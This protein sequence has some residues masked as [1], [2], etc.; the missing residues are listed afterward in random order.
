MY[1]YL[2]EFVWKKERKKERK[3]V[4][5]K[6]QRKIWERDK[7]GIDKMVLLIYLYITTRREEREKAKP[8]AVW[9]R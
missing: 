7:N 6:R 2:N 8:G 4:A 9:K 3:D 5:Q 1:V